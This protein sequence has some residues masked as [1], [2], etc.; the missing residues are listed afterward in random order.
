M[1]DICVMCGAPLLT[2]NENQYCDQCAQSVGYIPFLDME[3][4]VKETLER[5]DQT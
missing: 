3:S 1:D 2:E 5:E 4:K